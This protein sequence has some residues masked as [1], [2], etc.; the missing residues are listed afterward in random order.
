MIFKGRGTPGGTKNRSKIDQEA[1]QEA[2]GGKKT[3]SFFVFPSCAQERP[4]S[5]QEHPRAPQER[6]KSAQERP[7]RAQERPKSPKSAPRAPRAQ[8][9]PNVWG[10]PLPD[11]K[12]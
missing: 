9:H 8:T 3:Y 11:L 7:K 6:P 12:I 4:K 1:V 5:A 2:I 10:E